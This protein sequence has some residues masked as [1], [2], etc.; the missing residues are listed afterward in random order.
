MPRTGP[1]LLRQGGGTLELSRQEDASLG[2]SVAQ[3]SP[4]SY[5]T[6]ETPYAAGL[7]LPRR[8]LRAMRA[9][10]RMGPTQTACLDGVRPS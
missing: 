3:R 6:R 8:R 7:V 1:A 10:G 2:F 4:C 9:A 5:D